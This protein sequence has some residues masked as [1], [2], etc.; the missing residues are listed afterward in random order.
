MATAIHRFIRNGLLGI[1]QLTYL[2]AVY[3]Q[4][5]VADCTGKFQ[6]REY[7]EW[8]NRFEKLD[9]LSLIF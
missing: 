5:A 2:P 8:I 6:G 9:F 1:D 4:L 3:D 7:E